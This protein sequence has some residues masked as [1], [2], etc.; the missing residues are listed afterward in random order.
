LIAEPNVWPHHIA[1]YLGWLVYSCTADS[2]ANRPDSCRTIAATLRLLLDFNPSTGASNIPIIRPSAPPPPPPKV[3]ECIVC[4][5]EN[6]P[7]NCRFMPCMHSCVCLVDAQQF[8]S[9]HQPCPLCRRPIQNVQE[10]LFEHTNTA[11]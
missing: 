2:A 4:Y 5:G 10:G 6:G 1:E 9:S 11:F 8:L 7:I 3:R